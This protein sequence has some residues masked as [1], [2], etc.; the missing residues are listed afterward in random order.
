[1]YM[2]AKYMYIEERLA[3]AQARV[4]NITAKNASLKKSVKKVIA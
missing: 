2:M 1:M 3:L 4:K